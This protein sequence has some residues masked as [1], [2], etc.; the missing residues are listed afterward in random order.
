MR[1]RH[2]LVNGVQD[3]LLHLAEGVA[4]EHLHLD[5]R[6]LLVLRVDAVHHLRSPMTERQRAG[7]ADKERNGARDPVP[8]PHQRLVVDLLSDELVLA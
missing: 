7:S 4:V 5:L 6:A 2:V 8:P 3:L 1:M